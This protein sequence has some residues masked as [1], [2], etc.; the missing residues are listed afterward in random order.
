MRIERRTLD[1]A[2]MEWAPLVCTTESNDVKEQLLNKMC[3]DSGKTETQGSERAV[4]GQ[5]RLSSRVGGMQWALRPGMEH[6]SEG[7]QEP[8]S[9][10]PAQVMQSQVLPLKV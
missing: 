9:W 6:I 3:L 8:V 1:V 7:D 5:K 4:G 2:E 10:E